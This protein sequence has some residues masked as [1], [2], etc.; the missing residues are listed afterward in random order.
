MKN[1]LPE[2]LRIQDRWIL[3]RDTFSLIWWSRLVDLNFI[4]YKLINT[5]VNSIRIST[6]L[7]FITI[8]TIVMFV[9]MCVCAFDLMCTMTFGTLVL[10]E[11]KN[12]TFIIYVIIYFS[13]I[14]I[15]DIALCNVYFFQHLSFLYNIVK[16]MPVFGFS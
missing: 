7:T 14:N 16:Y 2:I 13:F 4:R 5:D 1:G 10:L 11:Y 6:K 8:K 12:F 15:Y 9:L 3:S